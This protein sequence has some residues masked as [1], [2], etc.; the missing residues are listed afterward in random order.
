MEAPDADRA[1]G[2]ADAY[3]P[4]GAHERHSPRGGIWAKKTMT[5]VTVQRGR[6]RIAAAEVT[7]DLLA[8]GEATIAQIA[9][10][11]ETDA[12]TLPRR[13]KGIKP[14]GRR[15]SYAT[16][17][18]KEVA[19]RIVKPGYSIEEY[20]RRMHP[21]EMPVGLMKEFWA[22]QKSRQSY[23]RD[24]G[25]LYRTSEVVAAF[26]KALADARTSIQLFIDGIERETG[27]TDPQRKVLRR[28]TDALIDDLR[29][30][31]VGAF[32]NYEPSTGQQ[33]LSSSDGLGPIDGGEEIL[34]AEDDSEDPD[35]I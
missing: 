18:I 25:D 35:D 23:E 20:I 16:Y 26:S 15:S 27:I 34:R 17:K 29:I 11:F 13:L 10:L 3:G 21:N 24:A 32:E 22:G 1:V 19:A 14:S 30:A 5:S 8:T 9:Q 7:S 6:D 2:H 12:K 4:P 28:R 33:Q 31:L